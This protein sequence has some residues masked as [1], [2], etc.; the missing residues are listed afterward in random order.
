MCI[1]FLLLFS[2]AGIKVSSL[3]FFRC[4]RKGSV[5]EYF[6]FLGFLGFGI[7][8]QMVCFWAWG[9]REMVWLLVMQKNEGFRY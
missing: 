2:F 4:L 7:F 5:W 8:F 6:G 1:Y 3:S 9:M